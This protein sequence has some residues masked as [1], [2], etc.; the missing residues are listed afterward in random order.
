[1][2]QI[3]HHGVI[4]MAQN[5]PEVKRSNRKRHEILTWKTLST[6]EGKTTGAS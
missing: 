5:E 4:N 3:D 2:R 1:M 6:R